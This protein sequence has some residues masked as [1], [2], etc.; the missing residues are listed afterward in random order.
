MILRISD[1]D[2]RTTEK[3]ITDLFSEFGKLH[4]SKIRSISDTRTKLFNTFTFVEI[5]DEAQ[6]LR[7]IEKHTN[8]VFLSRKI[9]IEKAG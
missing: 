5:E 1:L 9:T 6:A 3:D 2:S 4:T 8:T 7:A